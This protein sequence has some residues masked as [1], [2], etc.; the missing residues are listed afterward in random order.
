MI[1]NCKIQYF[2]TWNYITTG[3][4]TFKIISKPAELC[5]EF[6][7]LLM[8]RHKRNKSSEFWTVLTCYYFKFDAFELPDITVCQKKIILFEQLHNIKYLYFVICN[9]ILTLV[10]LS[11]I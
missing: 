10:V 8:Q 7:K 5:F 4:K 9:K 3:C 1:V 6:A 2:S 11:Q